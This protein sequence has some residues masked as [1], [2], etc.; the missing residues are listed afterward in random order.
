GLRFAN[1]LM[2]LGLQPQDRVAV[3][4]ENGLEAAD[5]LIA[6]AIGNYVRV[7]L[8]KKNA[9]EAHAHMIRNTGCKALVVDAKHLHELAG[10]KE[11]VPTLEHI[12]V[13]DENYE[14]WLDDQENRDPNPEIKLDD[15]HINRHSGGTT[16][17][18]KGMGFTHRAWMNMERDWTYRLPTLEEGDACIHVAPISH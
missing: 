11:A 3:L 7:P 14:S 17:L 8:Y 2:K 4:E 9:P 16:G 6:T 5:F 10:V 12:I 18:P 13:R 15:Y 1:A